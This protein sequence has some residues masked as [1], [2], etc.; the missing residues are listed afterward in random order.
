MSRPMGGPH[1]AAEVESDAQSGISTPVLDTP[2]AA[3]KGPGHLALDKA[4][5]VWMAV[6]VRAPDVSDSSPPPPAPHHH[7]HHPSPSSSA[8]HHHGSTAPCLGACPA[9][10]SR[11]SSPPCSSSARAGTGTEYRLLACL[12]A[13]L[14]TSCVLAWGVKGA[15]LP[16]SSRAT[17]PVTPVRHKRG[18]VRVIV[19]MPGPPHA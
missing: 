17:S 10:S 13:C 18:A 14:P 6:L 5:C 4:V 15:G 19:G 1:A 2:S 11:E 3:D 16:R 12:L 7:H 9:L 8:T